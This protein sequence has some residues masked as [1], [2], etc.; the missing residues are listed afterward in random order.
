MVPSFY[1]ACYSDIST[2]CFVEGNEKRTMESDTARKGPEPICA[3]AQGVVADPVFRPCCKNFFSCIL[4]CIMAIGKLVLLSVNA[5]LPLP[6]GRHNK[7]QNVSQWL[8]ISP[9]ADLARRM[10]KRVGGK[11][12][13]LAGASPAPAPG[14]PIPCGS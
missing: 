2:S 1:F 10:E 14:E 12:A 13:P 11:S 5:Q 8:Y 6:K 4:H 9:W 7:L 3:V